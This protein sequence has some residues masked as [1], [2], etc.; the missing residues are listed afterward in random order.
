MKQKTIRATEIAEF[1]YCPKG[2]AF[3]IRGWCRSF[4][5]LPRTAGLKQMR[6]MSNK[7]N[8]LR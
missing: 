1:A 6:G 8:A 2:M 5:R 7:V 4:V 3:E